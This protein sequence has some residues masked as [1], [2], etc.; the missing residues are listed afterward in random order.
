MPTLPEV[1]ETTSTKKD[2]SRIKRAHTPSLL[3]AKDTQAKSEIDPKISVTVVNPGRRGLVEKKKSTP[4]HQAKNPK[5]K[6]TPS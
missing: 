2:G 5:Q 3:H 1:K 4:L 6:L